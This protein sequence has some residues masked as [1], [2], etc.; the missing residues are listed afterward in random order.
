MDS[1]GAVHS[2]AIESYPVHTPRTGW[3]ESA[4]A[5]WWR[6]VQAAVHRVTA[7]TAGSIVSLGV[8]GQMHGVVLT[9]ASGAALRPAI[10]WADTRTEAY[11]AQFTALG[12]AAL[13]RLANPV[14]TGM[15]GPSLL[16]LRDH[17]PDAYATAR[18]ALQPK[19]WLR[20]QLTGQAAAEPSDAS[21]TLLYDVP[22]DEWAWS[23]IDQLGLRDDLL[24]PLI[25]SAAVAGSLTAAAADVLG[26]PPDLPVAAGAGDTPAAALGS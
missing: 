12:R 1:G 3:A 18:W 16:W 15:A 6:A 5:D 20:L 25:P 17:E 14:V 11:L 21:A 22:A 26:L 24:A 23:L 13:E 7:G 4:P 9:D 8:V 2:E 19:D 10:L